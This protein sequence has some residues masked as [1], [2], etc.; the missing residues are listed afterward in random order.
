MFLASSGSSWGT[1]FSSG[2]Q[3]LAIRFA[4]PT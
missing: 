1:G 3:D 2:K 4:N